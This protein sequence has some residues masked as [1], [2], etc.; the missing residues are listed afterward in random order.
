MYVFMYC[1]PDLQIHSVKLASTVVMMNTLYLIIN[2][3][4]QSKK[5]NLHKTSTF[6]PLSGDDPI[7]FLIVVCNILPQ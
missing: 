5:P 2:M 7:L 6:V 3:I 4:Y 1:N